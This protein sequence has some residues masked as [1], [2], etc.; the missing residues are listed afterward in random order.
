[1]ETHTGASEWEEKKPRG[2]PQRRKQKPRQT[3]GS[4]FLGP[5]WQGP[6]SPLESPQM[7]CS[8]STEPVQTHPLH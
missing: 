8:I 2:R 1:M 7:L 6:S 3:H 5:L 4:R